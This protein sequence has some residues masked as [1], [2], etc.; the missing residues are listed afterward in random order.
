MNS[1]SKIAAVF[2]LLMRTIRSQSFRIIRDGYLM[3]D[4]AEFAS[5]L[6]LE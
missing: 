6:R 1:Y 4:Q 2:Y 5:N 3:R